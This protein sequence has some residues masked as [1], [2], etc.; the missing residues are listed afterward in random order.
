MWRLLCS[1]FYQFVEK[2]LLMKKICLV[3]TLFIAV[4]CTLNA[5]SGKTSSKN[6]SFFERMDVVYHY[7]QLPETKGD[8]DLKGLYKALYADINI[9]HAELDSKTKMLTVISR[10]QVTDDKIV[11]MLKDSGIKAVVLRAEKKDA[12]SYDIEQKALERNRII[13]ALN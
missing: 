4:Q 2:Q 11:E 13:K 1:Y 8:A 7:L 12:N 5:A 10:P 6:T 3:L 9:F